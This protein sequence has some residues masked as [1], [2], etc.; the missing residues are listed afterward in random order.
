MDRCT[1][2]DGLLVAFGVLLGSGAAA[3]FADEMHRQWIKTGSAQIGDK[4]YFI[5]PQTPVRTA[6]DMMT[7]AT[8]VT[9]MFTDNREVM[10]CY[11]DVFNARKLCPLLGDTPGCVKWFAEHP[12]PSKDTV[13]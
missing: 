6:A 11:A 3:I 12:D 10:D 9:P 8:P 1:A 5:S 2:K 4:S 13:E 7:Q